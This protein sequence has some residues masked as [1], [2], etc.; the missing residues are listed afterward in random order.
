MLRVRHGRLLRLSEHRAWRKRAFLPFYGE[1]QLQDEPRHAELAGCQDQRP[2]YQFRLEM[3]SLNRP[4]FW[5]DQ[6]EKPRTHGGHRPE[7]KEHAAIPAPYR[8]PPA[9][10]GA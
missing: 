6:P 4:G 9:Q 3:R 1:P 10:H 8:N 5:H 2:H 7:H